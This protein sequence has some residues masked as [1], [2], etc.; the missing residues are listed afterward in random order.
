MKK[1]SAP[2]LQSSRT[3]LTSLLYS[4]SPT[5][6]AQKSP[7]RRKSAGDRARKAVNSVAAEVCRILEEQEI[8]LGLLLLAMANS[9]ESGKILQGLA[10]TSDFS[11]FLDVV[12]GNESGGAEAIKEWMGTGEFGLAMA[13]DV[14]FEFHGECSS[15]EG[16]QMSC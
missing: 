13:E 1:R 15:H 8:S 9:S 5:N 3:K 2:A 16:C 7:K 14:V 11:E 4:T 10:K 12:A 6:T